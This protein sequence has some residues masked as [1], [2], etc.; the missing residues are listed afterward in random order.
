MSPSLGSLPCQASAKAELSQLI[1]WARM[2]GSPIKGSSEKGYFYSGLNLSVASAFDS[3]LM[4]PWCPFLLHKTKGWVSVLGAA[5]TC[6]ESDAGNTVWTI[7][8]PDPAFTEL[9]ALG[10]IRAHRTMA[11]QSGEGWDGGSTGKTD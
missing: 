7:P 6:T 10:E 9:Q 11:P 5:L 8:A 3:S 1:P 4:S 2:W